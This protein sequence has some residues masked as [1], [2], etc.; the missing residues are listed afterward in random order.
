MTLLTILTC[1]D[2]LQLSVTLSALPQNISVRE[3]L[4]LLVFDS[5][6]AYYWADAHM[7]STEMKICSKQ[8]Y[9]KNILHTILSTAVYQQSVVFI[10]TVSDA[11]VTPKFAPNIPAGVNYH[12][13]SLQ[14]VDKS[15]SIIL[16]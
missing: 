5:P 7:D 13:V 10:Y 3:N 8:V 1:Y 11:F 2:S 4:S 9:L 12:K 15:V 6:A 16:N 14:M